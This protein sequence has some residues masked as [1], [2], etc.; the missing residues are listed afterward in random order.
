MAD[1]DSKILELAKKRFG[2]VVDAEAE[3]RP[4]EMDDLKFLAASPDDNW[5]WP[6]DILRDRT[7]P[8]EVGIRPCLTVNPLPQH[9]RQV[10]NEQ[11]MNRPQIRVQPVDDDGD[12]EVADIYNGMVRHIQVA[13]EAD[14]AYDLACEAQAAHGVG[15][16]RILTEYCDERSFDQDIV[17]KP[18]R[19]RFKVYLDPH[20]QHPAGK[21]AKFGFI[22]EDLP[23]EEYESL[24][25]D[26][27]P[28]N[29]GEAGAGD[30]S[31]WFPNKDTVR[32]AE[33]FA[34]ESVEKKLLLWA[35]GETSLE[36]E[37]RPEGVLAIDVPIQDRKT[38][39]TKCIWRKITGQAVLKTTELPTQYIPII[40]VVGNE[41][42]VDGK[43]VVSG[44]V[45]TAKDPVRMF[46]YWA[47]KETEVI[48]LAPIVPFVG[49]AGQFEGF[50]DRWK[51]ANRVPYAYLEYNPI[52]DE[53]TQQPFPAPQRAM[54]PL[55]PA[56]ITQAKMAAVDDLK[57]TT[58]FYDASLGNR[59]NEISGKAINARKVEGDV[60]S[61]HYVDNLAR[62]I[63]HAGRIIVDM[64]PK[65][66]DTKRIARIIG[67]D[68][69]ADH[70]MVDPSLKG[71][72]EEVVDPQTQRKIGKVYN[73]GVGK[74]DVVVTVG[75]SYTTKR[76]EAAE[77]MTQLLQANTALW[78][79]IGDLAVKNMDWPGAEEMSKRLK[80]MLLPAVQQVIKGEEEGEEP[81]PTVA[82][83][84]GPL[85]IS[86][87]AQ[88]IAGLMQKIQEQAQAME[89]AGQVASA[90]EEVKR[91]LVEIASK[92]E[93]LRMREQLID[94]TLEAEQ[95]K[96]DAARTKI[97]SE[98][99]LMVERAVAKL[100]ASKQIPPTEPDRAAEAA[101]IEER[102]SAIDAQQHALID[103]LTQAITLLAAPSRT[104]LI[105]DEATGKPIAAET[106]RIV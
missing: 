80:A 71:P 15:Y 100:E 7:T 53:G 61:F 67:E 55:P 23:K 35:N 58:G 34:L 77:S 92:A 30:Q 106:A 2:I 21:D 13:S 76:Q 95:A 41:W 17:V 48:A 93:T 82:T 68:G 98:M 40:R 69:E 5:Q 66:Y 89:D 42:I 81:E 50:E 65:V 49:A 39:I 1:A 103:S 105:R 38:R 31:L 11:R 22:I 24:H 91:Q 84:E 16:F 86:Q 20:I 8:G 33:Y 63:R 51:N 19:D 9:V 25:G 75:P 44:I 94:K 64:I 54:P 4:K 56:G 26:D 10:T 36:G 70:V 96:D 52:V 28:V 32:I 6:Q 45:R 88:L 72:Y 37:P 78:G 83:P 101:A 87:A 14:L 43:P 29:W 60:G 102:N 27:N 3:N 90:K 104:E 59:S 85:P 47:S 99:R 79:V 18:L 62:A 57:R 74:Y 97:I 12:P 73:L 46:N